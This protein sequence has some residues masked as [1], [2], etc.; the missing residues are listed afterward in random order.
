ME[1]LVVQAAAVV[2]A[3]PA[4]RSPVTVAT[5]VAPVPG[6]PAVPAVPALL[7]LYPGPMAGTAVLEALGAWEV[8]VATVA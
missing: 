3:A 1:R 2:Q 5:V 8:M 7:V 4:A 6:V